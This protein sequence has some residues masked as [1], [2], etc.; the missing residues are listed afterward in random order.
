M[1]L[2]LATH[3]QG[4]IREFSQMAAA[5]GIELLPIPEEL[6][7][8]ETGLTFMENALIK[9]RAAAKATG[10]PAVADDS[11]LVIEALDGRPGILSARYC[12][13]SDA[14]RRLKIL[15]EMVSVPAGKRQ[16]AFV[17]AMAL[18]LPDGSILK[19][20]EDR[21][22]GSIGYDCRGENGF[23]Y[24]P[25]FQLDGRVETSAMITNEE[26]NTLSH[27]GKA[28]RNIL[29]FIRSQPISV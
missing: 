14:D 11:G 7:P 13:G 12:E 23:G 5:H 28:W 21:W 26:K 16:A 4:K 24:D 25:I 8:E 22:R 19:T 27:R 15:E 20:T 9:A 3:N 1:K 2:V 18:C 10:L 6:D 29:D 17:C